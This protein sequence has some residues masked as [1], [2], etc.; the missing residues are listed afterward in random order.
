MTQYWVF[1]PY[2][3]EQLEIFDYVWAYDLKYGTIAFGSTEVGDVSKLSYAQMK[4]KYVA[5]Y[6]R[7]IPIDRKSIWRLYNE[8]SDGD[9]IIARQGRKKVIGVGTA[10]GQ[11]FYDVQRGKDRVGG[12][13]ADYYPNFIRVKWQ[14]KEIEFSRQV[15]PIFALWKIKEEQYHR[16]MEGTPRQIKPLPPP[17]R[18]KPPK[19]FTIAV[20]EEERNWFNVVRR[21]VKFIHDFLSGRAD[22]P[23][24]E[25]LCDLVQLCYTLSLYREGRDLF[26]LVDANA[27]NSWLYE[28]TSRLAKVCTLKANA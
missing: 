10:V 8:M 24:D 25:R 17:V 21:E 1:A 4:A 26:A 16:I 14:V 13:T 27:V 23:S 19:D 6:K 22:R 12:L 3:A 9:I 28:R 15:F 7:D 5:A 20:S 11:A 2:N 18:P